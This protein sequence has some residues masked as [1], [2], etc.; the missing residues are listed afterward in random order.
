LSFRTRFDSAPSVD[1]GARR[2]SLG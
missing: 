1:S 2:A